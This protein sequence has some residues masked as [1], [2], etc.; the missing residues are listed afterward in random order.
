MK[1]GKTLLLVGFAFLLAALTGCGSWKSD[2][3]FDYAVWSDDDTKVAFVKRYFK[4]KNNLTHYI[5]KDYSLELFVANPDGTDAVQIGG[6]RVGSV[7]DIFYMNDA[8]YVILGRGLEPTES[9]GTQTQTIVY[10]KISLDGTVEQ[11]GKVNGN[12]MV[13]CDGGSS[14][15]GTTPP[16]RVIPSRDGTTLAMVE[17]FTEC[18]SNDMTLTFLDSTTLSPIGQTMDVDTELIGEGLGDDA[19]F[20]SFLTM[21][22][23]PEGAFV[24]SKAF[25]MGELLVGLKFEVGG[26]EGEWVD[27]LM[28]D[29]MQVATSSGTTAKDGTEVTIDDDG[30]LS[31]GSNDMFTGCH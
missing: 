29:C 15:T 2:T 31:F 12:I 18:G 11:I 17:S 22:W 23:T 5:T 30:T 28:M 25:G 21:A 14:S 19:L 9:N 24:V 16:L 27:S 26:I 13:S 3:D 7:K 1:H 10:E 8:D 4:K 20:L 6:K